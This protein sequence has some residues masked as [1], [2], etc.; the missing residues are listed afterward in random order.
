MTRPRLYLDWNAAAPLRPEARAAMLAAM[1]LVGN[2]SSVHAEGRAAKALVE[3]ARAEVAA[4]VGCAPP[5]V[6]FT[7]GATEAANLVGAQPWRRRLVTAVE[8]DAVIAGVGGAAG[9]EIAVDALGLLDP[10]A[11]AAALEGAGPDCVVAVQ[12]ANSETG[13]LQP[14]T[15]IAAAVRGAGAQ[16]LV[17]ITQSVGRIDRR[18]DAAFDWARLQPDFACLS[19]HKLGGPK[20]AGALILR[21][22]ADIAAAIGGGG[23]ELGRRSGTEATLAIAGFGATAAAVRAELQGDS[24][25]SFASAERL[26]DQ[27]EARLTDAAPE[28][29]VMGAG[30]PRLANTACLALPGWRGEAQVIQMD[31]A[32]IAISAGSACS[33]GK[34]K[35]SRVLQAMGHGPETAACAIRVSIGPSTTEAETDAFAEAWEAAYRRWRDRRERGG[36]G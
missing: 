9:E 20:G 1:D 5:D 12:S 33:S 18:R 7:S 3:S 22:G 17:D 6:V 8:H 26:R 13:V 29:I 10:T 34:V 19:A 23:Q 11:L 2:P 32:G 16:L 25:G 28:L 35:A 15:E 14:L 30:A 36:V 21:P 24:A 31:L 27:L 4:L